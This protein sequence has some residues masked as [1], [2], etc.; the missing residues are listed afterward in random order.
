MKKAELINKIK[1]A[2]STVYAF[3]RKI[4]PADAAVTAGVIVLSGIVIIPSLA[5]CGENRSKNDCVKHMYRLRAVITEEIKREAETGDSYWQS[6]I[7]NGNYKRLLEAASNKLADD[8]KHPASDY[9]IRINE[10]KLELICKKHRDVSIGELNLSSLQN[11]R[12]NVA[13]QGEVSDDIIYITVSG[14]DTYYQ[15]EPL[16]P[17]HPEKTVYYGNDL[18]ALLSNL[19][20]KAVYTGG[21]SAELAREDYSIYSEPLDITKPGE[22]HLI[23][24]TNSNSVWD[25]SAY[26]SFTINIIGADDIPPLIVD[27][28]INGRFEL[29]AWDW[30]DFVEEAAQE[31][32]GKEFDASIIRQGGK[33]YYYPDG[34]YIDNSKPNTTPFEYAFDTDG[35]GSIA[36]NIPFDTES[37]ILNSSDGDK[38]HNGSVKAEN[39]H[40]YIWQDKPS[41][42]LEA[43]WIRVYCEIRKY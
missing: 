7:V 17:M 24:K 25:G 3:L 29:A 38:I 36:Y 12:I 16:D 10:N 31:K 32:D 9:Y 35:S 8:G 18:D 4:K 5:V 37:V 22:T 6:M 23:I 28:G 21:R 43:G 27:A 39:D 13:E 14:P 19:T 40:V 1:K 2:A 30:K 41:K 15:N 20:V 34:L 33:Y 11:V 26:G 42:E